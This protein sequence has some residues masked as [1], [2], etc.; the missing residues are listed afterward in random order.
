MNARSP[1]SHPFAS[2]NE[3]KSRR[4]D[5]S[6]AISRRV[7]REPCVARVGEVAER[8]LERAVESN[9]ERVASEDLHPP[10][11]GEHVVVAGHGA[12]CA[13]RFRVAVDDAGAVRDERGNARRTPIVGPRGDRDVAGAGLRGDDEPQHVRRAGRQ[14][15]GEARQATR[16]TARVLATSRSNARRPPPPA[17]TDAR[18]TSA[19]RPSV[20]RVSASSGEGSPVQPAIAAMGARRSI[21]SAAESSSPT[22]RSVCTRREYR[23]PSANH[24]DHS[25]ATTIKRTLLDCEAFSYCYAHQQSGHAPGTDAS[26]AP[27]GCRCRA[28]RDDCWRMCQGWAPSSRKARSPESSGMPAVRCRARSCVSTRVRGTTRCA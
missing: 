19:S 20:W 1:L 27:L 14:S 23:A 5:A 8:A 2:R 11:V 28:C 4:D 24:R 13:E 10:C 15:R 16:A 6:S 21:E 25:N 18:T 9:R 17:A 26:T 7:S 12:Q 22:A 3:R